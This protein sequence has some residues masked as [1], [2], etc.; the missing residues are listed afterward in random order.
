MAVIGAVAALRL[1]PDAGTDQLVDNDSAAYRATQDFEQKFGDDAVV[2]LVKGDLDQLVLTSDL[3]KLLSLEGC[4]S[5]NVAGGKV[6]T[7]EPAP[8]PCARIAEAKPA[9][10]VLGG[11]TFLNQS[12]I[13]RDRGPARAVAG[14]GAAGARGGRGG[15]GASARAQGL[16]RARAAS[17][18]RRQPAQEVLTQLPAADHPARDQVRAERPAAPRRPDLRQLGRL[19]PRRPR[20]A[21]APLLDLLAERRRRPD[22]DPAEARPERLGAQRGDRPDPR[23]GRRRRLPASATPT[24]VVSGAPVVVDGLADEALERDRRPADRGA[25]WS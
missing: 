8:A 24:Y 25:R 16:S 12:A 17:R 3:G 6:F 7:D 9:Q 21:E 10:A 19:R 22:P 23:R 13:Q 18:G 1:E 4:L 2:V 20:S 15:R 5:G 11:A 14:R